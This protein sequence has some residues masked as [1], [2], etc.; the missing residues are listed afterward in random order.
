MNW[1][2]DVCRALRVKMS[3]M[4]FYQD[5]EK[6]IDIIFIGH[7]TRIQ[8]NVPVERPDNGKTLFSK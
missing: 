4:L 1:K 2:V 5:Q 3:H 7:L 6:N 8:Q